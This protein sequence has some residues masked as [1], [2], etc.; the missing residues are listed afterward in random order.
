MAAN[1][2]INFYLGNRPGSTG[3]TPLPPGLLWQ[4]TVQE[5][6]R[7][8]MTGMWEQD[9][10]WW[11]R[12]KGVIAED[13]S[14]WL[15]LLAAKSLLFW[16]SFE[17]SNNKSLEYFTSVSFLSRHYRGWFGALA[18]LGFAGLVVFVRGRPLLPLASL[19]VGYWLAVALFFVSARYRLPIVPFLAMTASAAA[20]ELSGGVGSGRGRR[21]ALAV[22]A[23]L[24]VAIF[25]SWLPAG[26]DRIDPDFQMGQVFLGRGEPGRAEAHLLRSV[27]RGKGNADVLNSL[28]AVSFARGEWKKAEEYYLAA[29]KKGDFSEIYY[30]LGIVYERMEP[31]RN[32]E[33]FDAYRRSLERNPL[34]VRAR[35][36]MEYLAGRSAQ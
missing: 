14:R 21:A 33:A 28:G 10:Y 23:L 31:P 8:G 7:S 34:E 5:P 32:R 24:A 25:P 29:L 15:G 18:C 6:I 13:P 30:N 2:G 26:G 16:N 20:V 1:G 4:D 12:S 36:N 22:T 19:M 17:S 35:A 3:E 27:A 9:R 11:A